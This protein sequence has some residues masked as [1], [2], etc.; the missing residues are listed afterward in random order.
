MLNAIVINY[1]F[2]IYTV[3]LGLQDA[4]KHLTAFYLRDLNMPFS[5][6]SQMAAR[7]NS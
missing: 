5:M 3:S 4:L 7:P 6:I 1:I 2:L